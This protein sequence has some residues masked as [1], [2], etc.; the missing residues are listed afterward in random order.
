MN[1]TRGRAEVVVGARNQRLA[2]A[3][4]SLVYDEPGTGACHATQLHDATPL[5]RPTMQAGG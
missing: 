1:P 2:E 3:Q 5:E 4:V